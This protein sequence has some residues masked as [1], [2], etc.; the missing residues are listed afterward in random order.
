MGLFDAFISKTITN[1]KQKYL[2]AA[3]YNLTK[4]HHCKSSVNDTV[5]IEVFLEPSLKWFLM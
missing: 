2:K 4:P 3:F 1:K 5:Y